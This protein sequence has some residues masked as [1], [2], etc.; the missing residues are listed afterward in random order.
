MVAGVAVGQSSLTKNRVLKTKL[1]FV[2]LNDARRCLNQAVLHTARRL[3][4]LRRGE[5]LLYCRAKGKGSGSRV[6]RHPA[7]LSHS[8]DGNNM[9]LL[10]AHSVRLF[11]SQG[12]RSGTQ[13]PMT[14]ARITARADRTV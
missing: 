3:S 13:N 11:R 1:A 12:T 5:K 7:T 2:V 10:L 8:N 6:T 14:E 4:L 9:L